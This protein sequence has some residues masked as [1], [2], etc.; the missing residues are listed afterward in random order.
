[1]SEPGTH[2]HAVDGAAE[3][4]VESGTPGLVPPRRRGG[5][6]RFLT[7]V[8]I[9]RGYINREAVE[10]AIEK[11]RE[12]GVTPEHLL[13]GQH[14]ITPEQL[15]LAIAERYGLDH[16][17]LGAFKVDMGAAN[18]I[19]A[20]A[21]RRY[22]A[23][24]VS[25]IDENTLLLAMSDPANVLAIDDIQLLTRL[26]VRPAVATPED[27]A[28][29]ITRMSRFEDAVQEAVD[30]DEDGSS[31]LE[32]VDLRESAEDA[33]VIKLVHSIIGEA[34]ERGAS[35]IHFEAQADE[36][37]RP[38]RRLRVRMR[39]D[40]VL[41][42]TTTVPSRMVGG[43][44]SRIKIMSDLD[45]SERRL[46][47]DGRVGMLIEGRH[48]DVRVVTLPSVHG[49]SVVL[50]VLDKE[51]I[52]FEL[53]RLG[54]QQHELERFRGA[55]HR[56]HGAVLA[57]GPTGSGKSTTLYG[58]LA[59][60]NSSEKN[61]ITIEDP[62]EYQIEG[63]TQVQVNLKAGLTFAGGLRSMM[64]A[65]PD[66]LMVG[67]IRD[68]ETARIAVEGA[69]TG[70]MVLSTLHTNDAPTAITRLIEMGIEPFLVASAIDCIVAQRLARTLCTHCKR[71]TIIP[72]DALRDSGYKAQFDMEA[73]EPVGC[74]RCGGMG[75]RGRIGLFEVMVVSD[76]IRSL[77]LQRAPADQVGHVAVREGMRTLRE[78]GL[79][80][81]K[82]GLTSMAEVGRVTGSA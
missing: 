32:I 50:R 3:P 14:A 33:P 10:L 68:T 79:E 74:V 39:V 61:I 46:P 78:D 55:F 13:L 70:H 21:A 52:R 40:G 24:P 6:G 63:I 66:I 1:M 9:E 20:S 81:V 73:Y 2:L 23:V 26:D 54:M 18:L 11:A 56:S 65:D 12:A 53:D 67:E 7:D 76:E 5:T 51:S 45:I 16:L 58:A 47:Q 4:E 42:D 49:E 60:L 34:A 29:L 62:V 38:G 80:K 69:L 35:D 64:R 25:F 30:E 82:A 17:D 77:T 27:I 15:S 59:E 28:A 57:C 22:A 75:Y 71:R 8:L 72:V 31:P 36:K 37:G 48:V 43:V 19:T 44:I 41:T